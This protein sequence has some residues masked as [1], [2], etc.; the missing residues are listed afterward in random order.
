MS[1]VYN[2]CQFLYFGRHTHAGKA[3]SEELEN[4]F[5]TVLNKN[6]VSVD[7]VADGQFRLYCAPHTHIHTVLIKH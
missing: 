2:W 3:Q 6:Y 7:I 5:V 4:T 1:L